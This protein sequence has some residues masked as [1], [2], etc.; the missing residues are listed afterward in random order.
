MP[1]FD[2]SYGYHKVQGR[3]QWSYPGPNDAAVLTRGEMVRRTDSIRKQ[4]VFTSEPSVSNPAFNSM[5]RL[6]G[7]LELYRPL[8]FLLHDHCPSRDITPMGDIT[9]T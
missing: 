1:W 6:W 2:A 4:K 8:C 7:D 3:A 9:N 5:P